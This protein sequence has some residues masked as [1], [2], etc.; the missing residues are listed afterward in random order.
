MSTISKTVLFIGATWS[1][2]VH[3]L[4]AFRQDFPSHQA[5]F[6]YLKIFVDLGYLGVQKDY[7]ALEWFIPFRRPSRKG[8]NLDKPIE[9]TEEQ[10]AHNKF[11]GQNRIPVEHAIGGMKRF[12][13]LV[14]RFRNHSQI[15]RHEV[16]FLTAGI[17]NLHLVL[18]K[19]N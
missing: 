8:K 15:F 7:Q 3:D 12:N 9:L 2:S 19:S 17:W 5:W 16:I 6:E 10:K 14:N 13:C 18:A 1:G 4:K 11:V